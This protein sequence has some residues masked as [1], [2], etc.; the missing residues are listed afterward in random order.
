MSSLLSRLMPAKPAV[1]NGLLQDGL[2]E[3]VRRPDGTLGY[4]LTAKGLQEVEQ[5]LE[6]SPAARAYLAAL[7]GK[8][9]T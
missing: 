1:A 6:E 3:R 9:P 2:V 8:E 4:Q 5:L 7:A